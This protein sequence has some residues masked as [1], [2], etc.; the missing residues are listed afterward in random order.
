MSS[1][2]FTLLLFSLWNGFV[3]LFSRSWNKCTSSMWNCIYQLCARH[4]DISEHRFHTEQ[5]KVLCRI[6]RQI[7]VETHKNLW[8]HDASIDTGDAIMIGTVRLPCASMLEWFLSMLQITNYV[9]IADDASEVIIVSSTAGVRALILHVNL[10]ANRK[11]D[12]AEVLY[13]Q[14]KL[15]FNGHKLSA[16]NVFERILAAG[17]IIVIFLLCGG[18][19]LINISLTIWLALFLWATICIPTSMYLMCGRGAQYCAQCMPFCSQ[20]G[21][22]T[23]TLLSIL[24]NVRERFPRRRPAR[25]TEMLLPIATNTGESALETE[26]AELMRPEDIVNEVRVNVETLGERY[27]II[28]AASSWFENAFQMNMDYTLRPTQDILFPRNPVPYVY[29]VPIASTLPCRIAPRVAV[30]D[31]LLYICVH[32]PMTSINILEMKDLINKAERK[33]FLLIIM[34][35]LEELDNVLSMRGVT[36]QTRLHAHKECRFLRDMADFDVWLRMLTAGFFP[37]CTLIFPYKERNFLKNS[38]VWSHITCCGFEPQ[39]LD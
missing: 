21:N 13:L 8:Q 2:L 11:L 25:E 6:L 5:L 32:N 27:C 33:I 36:V 4:W 16:W 1:T 20:I 14:A 35:N 22:F 28:H 10:A 23:I 34:P 19:Y 31:G 15:G 3:A 30:A 12:H 18:E 29:A 39:I 37:H 7:G 38:S 24:R 17:F 9:H 26:Q